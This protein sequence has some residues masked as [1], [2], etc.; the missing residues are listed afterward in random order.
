MRIALNLYCRASC[1]PLV[2]VGLLVSAPAKALDAYETSDESSQQSIVVSGTRIARSD[3]DNPMPINVIEMDNYLKVG[4]THPYDALQQDPAISPGTGLS[5]SYGGAADAGIQTVSLRNMGTARTLTLVDGKRRVPGSSGTAAVDLNM[6]SPALIERIEVVTGGAAAIYGADAVTGVVNVI[7]KDSIDGLHI[8]ATTGISQQGDGARTTVSLATGG[9]FADNRG[10]FTIG[11]SWSKTNPIFSGDRDFSRNRILFQSNPLNTGANDGIVD[12]IMIKDFRQLFVGY[13]PSFYEAATDTVFIVDPINNVV[14]EPIGGTKITS[15]TTAF[16]SGGEGGQL[17]DKR[18]LRSGLEAFTASAKV[19]YDISDAITY[20]GRFDYGRSNY[21]S[22]TSVFRQDFR[23]NTMN[24]AGGDVALLDNPFVPTALADYMNA[25]DLDRLNISRAYYNFPQIQT[26]HTYESMT[27]EQGLEGKLADR[28][29]WNAFFQ[30]G[31]TTDDMS[32][33]NTPIASRYVAAR[34]VISDPVSGVPVCRDENARA[35]GCVPLNIFSQEALT[36]AQKDWMLTTRTM[37]YEVTQKIFGAGLSGTAFSL[38]YGDVAF[39]TGIE[40]RIETVDRQ[41]DPRAASGDVAYFGLVGP[42]PSM[43]ADQTITELYGE[44]VIPLLADLP[45]IRRLDVEGAYRYSHYKDT[46]GG[47]N[48]WKVGATWDVGS[49]LVLRGVRSRSVRAP[50]FGE[51]YGPQTSSASGSPADTCMGVA[52]HLSPTRTANCKALGIDAPLAYNQLGPV[53]ISGGNPDLNPETADTL[54]L[55]AVYQP[56]F[57]PGLA[58]TADYWD[59]SISDVIASFGSADVYRLCTDLPS[60]DNVFCQST[61]RD[62]VT[63][64][65]T[66]QRTFLVNAQEL[67]RSGIDFGLHYRRA[68]G[69]GQLGIALRASYLLEA[70]TSTTPGLEAGDVISTGNYS[71]PRLK[72]TM[73][74]NYGTEKLDIALNTRFI[75]SAKYTVGRTITAESYEPD[76]YNIGAAVY[77]DLSIGFQ[78]DERFK[79]SVGVQNLFNVEPKEIAAIQYGGGGIYDTIGRYF[80]TNVKLAL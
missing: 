49:G 20:R 8:N 41:D 19:K 24:N 12:S 74:V 4:I 60:I 56:R 26:L 38:P 78:P 73:M 54:T 35:A 36:Q 1:I 23:A 5:N 2:L 3:L 64:L 47:T 30:Y 72:G 31:R 51:L 28:L 32:L 69:G 55:G 50:N 76:L 65:A 43:K 11:G 40:R 67:K 71:N 52:Y 70:M 57:L 16:W 59:I 14:R 18:M 77:N 7:T 6:I 80:F 44:A 46:F 45:F 27:L 68:I 17:E 13:Q 10:S 75:G 42:I 39:A 37:N 34:D 48:T 63:K 53:I 62:P 33:T 58:V 61:E 25:N 29:N 22:S 66:I 79:F 15:G 21:S 9:E